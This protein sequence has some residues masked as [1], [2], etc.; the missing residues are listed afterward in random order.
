MDRLIYIGLETTY[1]VAA[2][3]KVLLSQIKTI[4]IVNRGWIL[5]RKVKQLNNVYN[6]FTRR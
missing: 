1:F 2:T 5:V 6:V 3:A 4:N